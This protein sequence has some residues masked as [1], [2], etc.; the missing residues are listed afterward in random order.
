MRVYFSFPC[1]M[2]EVK[3]LQYLKL[4]TVASERKRILQFIYQHTKKI[5]HSVSKHRFYQVD[6]SSNFT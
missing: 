1:K 4:V 6:K 3:N 2:E 5:N